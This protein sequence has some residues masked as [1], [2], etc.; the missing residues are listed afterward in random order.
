MSKH[1][2]AT[3]PAKHLQRAPPSAPSGEDH[4][5]TSGYVSGFERDE[6]EQRHEAELDIA[7]GRSDI[8]DPE[9]FTGECAP[10][11]IHYPARRDVCHR[12]DRELIT[13][14]RRAA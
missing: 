4:V 10:P 6:R 2:R 1:K 9:W 13:A 8:A 12:P 11:V 7:E 5:G 14:A 3:K